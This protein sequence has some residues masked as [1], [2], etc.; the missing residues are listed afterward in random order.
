MKFS[1]LFLLLLTTL[2]FADQP[3]DFERGYQAGLNSQKGRVI[4][5][6]GYYFQ[7]D[8]LAKSCED[9]TLT[10]EVCMDTGDQY[11]KDKVCSG[12]CTTNQ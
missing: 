12:L 4:M 6:F 9:G 7:G 10:Q 1:V 2:A 8:F 3:S 11:G 5:A